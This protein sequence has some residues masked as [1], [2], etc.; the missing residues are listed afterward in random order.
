VSFF[1]KGRDIQITFQPD[2]E[3][4]ASGLRIVTGDSTIAAERIE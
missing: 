4:R 2:A 1:S 3:V